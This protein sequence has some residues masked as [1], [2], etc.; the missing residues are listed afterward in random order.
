MCGEHVLLYYNYKDD[1]DIHPKGVGLLLPGSLTV[2]LM[3][4]PASLQLERSGVSGYGE[5]VW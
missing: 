2:L 3:S 5:H 4:E 1:K